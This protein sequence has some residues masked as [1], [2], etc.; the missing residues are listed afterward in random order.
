MK[1]TTHSSKNCGVQYEMGPPTEVPSLSYKNCGV[2]CDMGPTIEA[3]SLTQ[4]QGTA[5]CVIQ[6]PIS[7]TVEPRC[8]S[9]RSF[10]PSGLGPTDLSQITINGRSLGDIIQ[11][12]CEDAVRD[13]IEHMEDKMDELFGEEFDSDDSDCMEDEVGELFGE[14]FDSDLLALA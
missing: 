6:A 4:A 9:T 11:E 5:P 3:P 2:Q 7:V 14:E 1:I 12:A 8:S 10:I 13:T